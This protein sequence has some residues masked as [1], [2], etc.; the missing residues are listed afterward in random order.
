MRQ[1]SR[2]VLV[3]F[4]LIQAAA[5]AVAA[6]ERTDPLGGTGG[7]PIQGT[8][9]VRVV[10]EGTGAPLPGAFVMVGP[11]DGDPFP[12]N[13]G[14]TGA[15][16]E[17]DFA[18][19]GLQGPIDVTA[20]AAGRA[21]F[22]LVG[23]DAND[24]VL[25]LRPVSTAQ[26]THQVGDYVSGIDVNNGMFNAG[27]GFIDM[28]FVVPTLRLETLLSFDMAGL[29]G[30][31]E[32]IEILGQP[33]AIP[34]NIF[35][36]SQYEL[37][38]QIVKDHY[39]LYLAEGEYTLAAL[40]GRVPRDALLQAGDITEII[41]LT[42]WREIDLRDVSVSGPTL[43]AD[44]TVDPDLTE[45]ATLNLANL[46]ANSLTWCFS[47]GDLDGLEGLGR[48]VPLGLT[49]FACPGG[50]APCSGSVQLTTTP[51]AG[52]F[53]GMAY[54]PAAV[55]DLNDTEDLLILLSRAPHPQGYSET[56]ASFF[57]TL[58]LVYEGGW[59]LWND[60]ADPQTGSPAVHVQTARITNGAG[61]TYWEFLIPGGLLALSAPGLPAAA[62][63]GPSGG[64]LYIWEQAAAG[65]GY[66][67]PAFDFNAFAFRD[68]YAHVSHL[69][70]DRMEVVF[71]PDAA[72]AP[73]TDRRPFAAPAAGHPNPFR[74]ETA[75][76]FELAAAAYIDL[77]VYTP[78][79]R[80]VSTLARDLFPAGPHRLLWR[81]TDAQD[82]PLANGVYLARLEGAGPA[83]IWR[84]LLQ[85]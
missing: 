47:A 31:P 81:G 77:S 41:P 23:V 58:D 72:R 66:A 56:L 68:L 34:S 15:A 10:E 13:W 80:R 33:Y 4:L 76:G 65:L 26:A 3:F 25:A 21:Y 9:H 53:A 35:L 55:V 69:A 75:L 73:E 63:P 84:L 52:E 30:P 27:D 28:A 70:S 11:R 49:S 42:D 22:T 8:L 19:A 6:L 71:Q 48:L 1:T 74:Q 45:T 43:D 2:T 54:F 44:L 5:A 24:L 83:R 85:R 67:L 12:G 17:I 16:G 18:D 79:G 36:P 61:E 78:D 57:H 7:G 60:A 51:A 29:F 82:R 32:I 62:P 20:G 38:L 37:F 59:F 46:P 39:Y 64:G 50:S 40:S 14:F